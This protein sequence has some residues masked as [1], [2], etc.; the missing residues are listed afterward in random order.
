MGQESILAACQGRLPLFL[1][2]TSRKILRRCQMEQAL[3]DALSK[4][5]DEKLKKELT[6]TILD[7]KL[8]NWA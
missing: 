5:V 4:F 3:R 8:G 1:G 2:F 7:D 6:W